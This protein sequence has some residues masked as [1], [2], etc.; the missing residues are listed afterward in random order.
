MILG[1]GLGRLGQAAAREGQRKGAEQ[2]D[3]SAGDG[4]AA[5]TEA[6]GAA[7]PIPQRAGVLGVSHVL[8]GRALHQ[9]ILG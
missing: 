8:G 1:L 7:R 2:C 3:E 6:G 9:G 5:A 4:T